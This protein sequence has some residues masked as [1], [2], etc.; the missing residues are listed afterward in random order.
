M[1]NP[2]TASLVLGVGVAA[3]SFGAIL[4]RFAEAPSSTV[5]AWR[6]VFAAGVLLP[7][8]VARRRGLTRR[9]VLLATGAGLMLALHFATWIESVGLTTVASSTVFVNTHPIFV[10]LLVWLLG[11]PG[12]RALWQGIAL[13]VIG[14][15]LISWA[16]LGVGGTAL[17]GNM[18]ALVGGIAA[19]GYLVVGARMR[20]HGELLPY[21]TLAYGV[22]AVVLLVVSA[23]LG[24]PVRPQGMSWLWIALLALGPQ[25]IGHTSVN[26]ALRRVAAP[27]VAVAVLGEPVFATLWAFLLFAEP[28]GAVQGVGMIIIMA[29][30]L[31]ALLRQPQ[32][33]TGGK[34]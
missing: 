19:S 32:A 16:D 15:V 29:G 22:A 21:V 31:R 28:V 8:A 26:W 18:L 1:R 14:G 27:A 24:A 3:I 12:D 23:G 5:A 9:G 4:V 11:E 13:A 6:M 30:I 2:P 34:G 20:Q 33:L 10:G 25:L 7:V 17:L